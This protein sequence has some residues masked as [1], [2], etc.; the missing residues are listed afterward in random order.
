M[1]PNVARAKK[2]V[3][4]ALKVVK[5][6]VPAV[7]QK[8]GVQKK[9]VPK[10]VKMAKKIVK[11]LVAPAGKR[12]LV[13]NQVQ[14]QKKGGRQRQ[15]KRQG[16]GKWAKHGCKVTQVTSSIL[17]P[18][19]ALNALPPPDAPPPPLPP[20]PRALP[21]PRHHHHHH[22]QHQHQHH[23]HVRSPRRLSTNKLATKTCFA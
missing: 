21:P 18:W 1:D 3:K 20:A 19:S 16:A 6:V 12:G 22:H 15:R 11:K 10:L 5:K 23:H 13:A 14:N 2:P 17:P 8:A 4:K 7:A 9:N